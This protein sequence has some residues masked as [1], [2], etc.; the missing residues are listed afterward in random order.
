MKLTPMIILLILDSMYLGM[1]LLNDGKPRGNFNFI[2]AL[3][4]FLIQ[5]FL[6]LWMVN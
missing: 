4:A 3:I 2:Y 6:I 1:A 5:W